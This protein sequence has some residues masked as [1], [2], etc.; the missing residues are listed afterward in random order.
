MQKITPC[1]WFDNQAEEAVNLY[2]SIFKNS[3]TGVVA[4]YGEAGAEVS[5]M[6]KGSVM[7]VAFQLEGQDFIA[8]NGGPAFKFTP[9][10]SFFVCCERSEDIDELWRRLGDGGTVL[11]ALDK[12]PFSEKYGRLQDRYGLSWQLNLCHRAQKI[13]PALLFVGKQHSKAEDAMDYYVSVFPDSRITAIARY[14]KGEPDPEGTVKYAEFA[15]SGQ[16]FIAMDSAFAHLFTFTEAI[17]FI[18]NCKTQKEVDYYWQKL[19]QG[20]DEKAQVCGWLKD[21]YGVSWQVVPTI[22]DKLLQDK[23]IE[24]SE[25]VMKAMLQ[26]KKIEISG[27][28]RAYGRP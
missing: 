25:R 11:M 15:L 10:I 24:K 23:D 7:T 14:E 8:L 28:K 9:A 6:P 5:G 1:L 20:G 19:T 13:S 17:S 21:K 12:Y 26:M 18:V 27:L 16:E 3:K 22:L 2:T 4:R